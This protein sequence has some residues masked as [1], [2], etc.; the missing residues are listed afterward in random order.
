MAAV[1]ALVAVI[2]FVRGFARDSVPTNPAVNSFAHNIPPAEIRSVPAVDPAVDATSSPAKIKP[3][4]LTET[5][6]AVE[7]AQV[8]TVRVLI[9]AGQKRAMEALLASIQAGK[10]DGEVL[11]AEKPEKSLEELQVSPLDFSL[12]EVKPLGA[13][14]TELPSQNEETN[15]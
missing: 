10:V 9:P 14:G 3:L 5:P 15:R 13:A 7:V 1:V 12:I 8:E 2:V 11:L 6:T 4:G